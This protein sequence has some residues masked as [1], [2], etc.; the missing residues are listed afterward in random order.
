MALIESAPASAIAF[1]MP[2]TSVAAG[3]SF[4]ISGRSVAARTDAV[5]AAAA[6]ASSANWSPPAPTFGH[7]MLSSMPATPG[8]PSS[9]LATSV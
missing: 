4:T 3:E 5:T 7:E 6:P 2:R 8:C 1:A 9:R